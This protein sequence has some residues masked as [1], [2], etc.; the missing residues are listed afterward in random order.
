MKKTLLIVC[1]LI[2]GLTMSAQVETPA[3]Q[4]EEEEVT[5]VSVDPQTAEEIEE[6]AAA[7]TSLS[8]DEAEEIVD[9]VTA[10]INEQIS[11]DQEAVIGQP[12]VV[13]EEVEETVIN[14]PQPEPVAV[15]P[16]EEE[17]FIEEDEVVGPSTSLDDIVNM[18][19]RLT[20]SMSE[21]KH[22]ESVWGRKG[23]FNIGYN[24]TKLEPKETYNNKNGYEN[25]DMP[26]FKSDWAF[27]I[28][29]GRNYNILKKAIANI[30]MINIDYLPLDFNVAH[31]KAE[32]D[33]KLFN[34][35]LSY[36]DKKGNDVQYLP[37]DAE[38]YEFTYGMNLGPS[39][40]LAPFTKI[41]N[42]KGLHFL[43]FN[44]YYHIGYHV[45][46]LHFNSKTDQDKNTNSN[47]NGIT[48][49]DYKKELKLNFGHGL[50]QSFGVSLSWKAIGVGYEIK[51][52]EVTYKPL[53]TEMFGKNNFKFKEPTSRIY[54]QLRL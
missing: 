38:K 27:G 26:T 52:D 35:S 20:M 6:A 25:G 14:I 24:N 50:T 1:G 31:F 16:V 42:M 11:D 3:V 32:R 21:E 33:G 48:P 51:W 34:S 9:D 10:I 53:N 30:V 36:T 49:D 4:V 15:E 7:V 2:G 40:T 5:A 54:L 45:S 47:Y 43:K 19:Q 17:E 12:V 13:K 41:R 18:Q 44:V 28:Q 22:F 29:Y 8:E 23:F 37:W 39:I 46:L